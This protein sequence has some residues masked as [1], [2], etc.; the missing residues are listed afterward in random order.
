[1]QTRNTI[2]IRY[3]IQT[4][5]GTRKDK[6]LDKR[7]ENRLEEG[8]QTK[9]GEEETD[10]GILLNRSEVLC[11]EQGKLETWLTNFRFEKEKGRRGKARKIFLKEE[12]FD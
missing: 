11:G 7:R 10:L 9:T 3:L 12:F 2:S 5:L 4:G 1:M 8:H 6:G